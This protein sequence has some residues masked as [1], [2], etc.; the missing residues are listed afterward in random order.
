MKILQ[1]VSVGFEAGGAEKSVNLISG[2]LRAR[3]H[4]V[5]ILATERLL[6]PERS[7]EV[8]AD[9]L[10]PAIKGSAM[11]RVAGYRWYRPAYDM[12][13]ELMREFRPDVVHLHTI[14]EFS[15][16]ILHGTAGVPRMLTVHGPED[17]TL[18]LLRWN[19]HSAAHGRLSPTD[20][21]RYLYLRYFQRPGYLP[22][23][24]KLDR[25]VVPSAWMGA[26]V[27]PDVGSVPISVVPNGVELPPA[28]AIRNPGR[29]VFVGRLEAVKG[30]QVLLTALAQLL[31]FSPATTLTI[32][33]DGTQRQDLEAL[34]HRLRLNDHVRFLGHQP[35]TEVYR[36][37]REAGVLVIPSIWPE[38]FAIVAREALAVGRPIVASRSGGLPE[39]VDHDINGLLV[40]PGDARD[41]AEALHTLLA[42]PDRVH[43][44][45]RQ[46]AARAAAYGAETFL[47]TT[48]AIYRELTADR[49]A[50]A[51]A[52]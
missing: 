36:Q 30:V 7:S 3:G 43:D 17:W 18:R 1:V 52:T 6:T 22:Q 9:R 24:R 19:L 23:I 21:A 27:A 15:P 12:A 34:S 26:T 32:V 13:R 29:L 41:L 49:P 35:S 2:G 16:A 39:V 44:M 8:F 51:A 48:E 37:I 40:R 4:E 25:V 10:I 42:D 20:Q 50:V 47:D 28:S 33:G 38:N 11:R 45:G 46:S 31:P 5:Q 14:G